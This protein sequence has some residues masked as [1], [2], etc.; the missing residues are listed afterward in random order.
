MFKNQISLKPVQRKPRFSTWTVAERQ[1]SKQL[2]RQADTTN[3]IVAF[4]DFVK[5]PQIDVVWENSGN[6]LSGSGEIISSLL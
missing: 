6:R 2:E 5:A 1:T 3:R 4:H